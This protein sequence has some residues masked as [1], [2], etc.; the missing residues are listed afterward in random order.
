MV[1]T[2][3][4]RAGVLLQKGQASVNAPGLPLLPRAMS[5][6]EQA[7]DKQY[8]T[9]TPVKN[10]V[11]LLVTTGS[12]GMASRYYQGALTTVDGTP[13]ASAEPS[14]SFS[15]NGTSTC[16]LTLK[17]S[18]EIHARSLQS[19]TALNQSFSLS[20]SGAVV[21]KPFA[22][23]FYFRPR[24]G[25]K[26]TVDGKIM[27]PGEQKPSAKP[28]PWIDCLIGLSGGA[29]TAELTLAIEASKAS[30]LKVKEG[31][32]LL[33]LADFGLLSEPMANKP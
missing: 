28:P 18:G 17:E 11:A 15:L 13:N 5:A 9:F 30:S 1:Q 16:S 19:T 8:A 23:R 31:E 33:E 14:V 10:D 26:V 22:V 20:V 6:D 27:N 3:S 32:T 7:M 24:P 2:P 29:A 25:S 21:S 12:S 4:S